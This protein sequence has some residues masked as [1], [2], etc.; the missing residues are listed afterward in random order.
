MAKSD[1][2]TAKAEVLIKLCKMVNQEFNEFIQ[3]P[4]VI[5]R[6]VKGSMQFESERNQGKIVLT[7]NF[8]IEIPSE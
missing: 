6:G 8:N 7:G 4:N 5:V 3:D 1:E 2:L